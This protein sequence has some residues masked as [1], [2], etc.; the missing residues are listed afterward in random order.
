MTDP[1]S[2]TFRFTS[3]PL[4]GL[5][6][7]R[8]TGRFEI[9]VDPETRGWDIAR[10]W[11]DD[12]NDSRV[13]E[14]D[15]AREHAAI[16]QSIH[17]SILETHRRAIKLEVARVLRHARASAELARHQQETAWAQRLRYVADPFARFDDQRAAGL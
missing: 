16:W 14:V 13:G 6:G 2:F 3:L 9:V 4:S 15:I 8:A 5:S 17:D 1:T 7:L 10:I 11:I 12:E